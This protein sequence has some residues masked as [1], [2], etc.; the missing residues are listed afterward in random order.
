[1]SLYYTATDPFDVSTDY[2]LWIKY[3]TNPELNR[4]EQ[5]LIYFS[6]L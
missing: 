2:S 5:L 3:F 1:M 6:L 4:L